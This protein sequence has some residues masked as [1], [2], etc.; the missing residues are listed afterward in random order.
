MNKFEGL[1]YRTTVNWL[2]VVPL[3]DKPY[4]YLEIG[5]LHG[6]NVVSFCESYGIHKDTKVYVIDPFADYAEYREYEGQQEKNHEIFL[7]NTEKYKDKINI[8]RDYSHKILPELPDDFFHIA[9]IDGNHKADYVLEDA[10][11]SFR[12]LKNGG[13]LIFDDADWL[14]D[15]RRAIDAFCYAFHE[16]IQ[17][18]GEKNSQYFV[19]K[20]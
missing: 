10:V 8:I 9:Y 19:K 11:M 3:E 15:V 14:D 1:V 13:W 5:A 4:T 16:R 20:I 6:A 17:I 2:G 12:K 18:Y 7:K